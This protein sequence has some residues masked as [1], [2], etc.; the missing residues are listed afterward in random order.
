MY[1]S[2]KKKVLRKDWKQEILVISKKFRGDIG[3][4]TRGLS[5]AKRALYHWAISP[6]SYELSLLYKF[7]F[8]LKMYT[9]FLIFD[10]TLARVLG[11]L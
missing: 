2:N 4:R 11:I 7:L 6:T 9:V 1:K 10:F 5:H 3:D 8:K